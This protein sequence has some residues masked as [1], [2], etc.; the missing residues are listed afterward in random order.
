MAVTFGL[1]GKDIAGCHGRDTS[2]PQ[3]FKHD[4]GVMSGRWPQKENH[5]SCLTVQ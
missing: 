5:I 4:Y 3:Q 1:K 2:F